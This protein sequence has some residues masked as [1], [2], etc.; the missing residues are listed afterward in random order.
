[1]DHAAIDLH[2]KES[3]IRIVTDAG[4]V[5]DRR[6][7]T[8][9]EA[10]RAVFEE[11]P[12]LRVLLE[13]STESEWVAQVLEALGHSPIV[14][15]PN[16]AP[17][18]GARSRRVKTDLRDTVALAEACGQGI[19][20]PVHR[21]SAPQR[22]R[23]WELGVRDQ[24][25]RTR[26][27]AINGVRAMTRS[28]GG[29]VRS[30]SSRNFVARVHAEIWP[31][32]IETAIAPLCALITHTTAALAAIE[33]RMAAAAAADPRC[34]RLMTAPAIGAVTAVAFVAAI[35]DPR[36]FRTAS[37]VTQY[38][39]LV[40]HERSSGE[41]QRRGRVIRAA[42]PRVQ[43][44]LVQ[45]AWRI[46]CG[47]GTD[48]SALRAWAQGVATRRGRCVAAVALARRLAR[49]LWGMWRTDTD[50]RPRAIARQLAE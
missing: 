24:L 40:P 37:Q 45:A 27:R 13:A 41:R 48:A 21:R 19:Y 49:I 8:T 50:Y 43:A 14:A 22:V 38:L 35:D 1:M 42:Q 46:L 47:R 11:R 32:E 26:T 9:R 31:P 34:Q 33:A 44:L 3:Q 28:V 5:I 12:P 36:R 6:V 17:M 23:Q 15:D 39:G 7:A 29:R 30:G 16:W 2:K 20:R 10:L 4:E 18:Y 25:M